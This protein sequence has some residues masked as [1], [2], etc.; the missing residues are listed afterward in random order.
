MADVFEILVD[1]QDHNRR[2]R[3]RNNP[4]VYRRRIDP[5][6]VLSDAEFKRH[7]RFDKQSV[8]DIANMLHNDLAQPNNRG[9]PLTPL[10]QVCIAL[11]HYAGAHFQRVSA[12]CA[13]VS[14]TAAWW[15]IKRVT[16]ALC[17]RKAEF[18]RMPTV[19]DMEE[20]AQ[21]MLERFHLPRFAFT[22]DGMVVVFKGCPRRIPQTIVKQNYWNRKQCYAI[23]CQV[24]ANDRQI[25]CDI[26]CDWHGGAHDAAIWSDSHAKRYIERQRRFLLAGDSAYP[27]SDI[28]IKPYSNNEAQQDYAKRVFNARLSGLRTVMSENVYGIWKRRFPCLSIMRSDLALAKKTIY[29]T[30]ILHNL[31]II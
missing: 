11:N 5:T 24:I 2:A 28:L 9:R 4:P 20:T 13:G 29:A 25:T 15:A 21:R 31:S 17:D 16:Y 30:A 22:V 3:R 14:Q 1:L 19:Q 8:R 7:F 27:I 10:Q 12:M 18:I 26:D 23:N 6:E